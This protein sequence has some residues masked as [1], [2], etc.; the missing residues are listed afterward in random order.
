MSSS[1]RE[2]G[3][4]GGGGRRRVPAR[5]SRRAAR[6]GPA[7]D[8]LAFHG[9][10]CHGRRSDAARS[11]LALMKRLETLILQLADVSELVAEK[12]RPEEA[13][14]HRPSPIEYRNRSQQTWLRNSRGSRRQL[15]SGSRK[16]EARRRKAASTSIFSVRRPTAM[17]G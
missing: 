10:V 1:R 8:K 17:A 11:A 6:F 13:I 4:R 12:A 14:A 9:R 16:P 2:A 3:D 5:A 7:V 15:R